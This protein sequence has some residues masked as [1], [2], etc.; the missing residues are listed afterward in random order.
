LVLAIASLT[1]LAFLAPRTFR[2]VRA[3]IKR[4]DAAYARSEAAAF[5]HLRAVAREGDPR[6]TYFAL[7]AWL[8]RFDPVAPTHTLK[9]F[10]RGALDPELDRQIALIET[11]LFGRR[12]DTATSG[13][14]PRPSLHRITAARRRLLHDR[15]AKAAPPLATQLNPPN[16]DMRAP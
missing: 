8:L 6:A 1:A 10:R 3:W 4:R 16:P 5:A 7:L 9:E 15:V 13:W 14:S 2:K 11:A 12:E